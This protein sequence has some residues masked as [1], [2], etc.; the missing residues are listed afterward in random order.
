MAGWLAGL[1]D[2]RGY[3]V[4]GSLALSYGP[5][6]AAGDMVTVLESL[7]GFLDRVPAGVRTAAGAGPVD[8]GVDPPTKGVGR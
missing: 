3:E 4:I 2:D 8:P 5:A 1:G 6:S 7:Q